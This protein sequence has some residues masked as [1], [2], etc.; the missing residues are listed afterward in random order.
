MHN[1]SEF[2]YGESWRQINTL[3]RENN[4]SFDLSGM[5]ESKQ[6]FDTPFEHNDMYTNIYNKKEVEEF[7][8]HIKYMEQKIKKEILLL[9]NSLKNRLLNRYH[10]NLE[11][12]V[13]SHEI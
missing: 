6:I 3:L 10:K 11:L 8:S 1:N 9:L 12:M 2:I 5:L 13:F 7:L 4:A